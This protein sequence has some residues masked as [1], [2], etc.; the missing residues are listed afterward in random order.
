MN[1]NSIAIIVHEANRALQVEQADPTIPVSPSWQAL[2]DH[3]KASAIQGV[4]AIIEGTVTSPE[5]SHD[6]W[7][8]FKVNDG[9][10][11]GPVKDVGKKEH[12]LLVPY[13]DL[14]ESQKIK[15]DLFSGIVNILK[16]A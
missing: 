16:D 11:W 7:M 4:R 13:Y 2:D 9:W 10:V 12:P 15:G 5:Q 8:Q 1:P 6:N 14:P 3:T